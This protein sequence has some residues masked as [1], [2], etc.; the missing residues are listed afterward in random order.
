[1]L[2]RAE[3]ILEDLDTQKLSRDPGKSAVVLLSLKGCVAKLGCQLVIGHVHVQY[4][5]TI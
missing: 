1:M 4:L 2:G 5:G 3:T